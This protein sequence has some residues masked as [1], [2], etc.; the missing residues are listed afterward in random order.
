VGM[1]PATLRVAFRAG[2]GSSKAA[3]PRGR[4]DVGTIF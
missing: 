2:R 4:F 3:F 1:H